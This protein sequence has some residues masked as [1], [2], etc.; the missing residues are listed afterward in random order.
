MEGLALETIHMVDIIPLLPIPYPP[1]G[2]SSYYIPCPN[3]DKRHKDKHLN[4]NLIKDVFRCPKCG[5]FGGVFDLYCRYTHY[6]REGV[7]YKLLRILSGYSAKPYVSR[8]PV[9]F[10][11]QG[12]G[13]THAAGLE[14]RHE[15]YSDLLS[16]LPLA[17]DH[18][19][20]L[21]Q[22][23]LS[24]QV[25][26]D[27]GYRTISVINEKSLARRLLANGH[28]LAGVP[29]FYRDID[30]Q[31]TFISNQRGVLIPVRDIKGRIQGMQVRRDNISKRKYRWISSNGMNGGQGAESWV[32][33]AGQPA[34][35]VILT[36]GPLKADVIHY[37]TG[38]TILAVPGVNSLKHLENTLA[39][40]IESGTKQVMTAFDMDF[41]QNSH[42]QTGYTEL[43]N[44]LGR[45]DL[46][47][48]TYLWDPAFNGLDDYIHKNS[49]SL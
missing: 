5:F 33:I 48:G 14:I 42:V 36:E 12:A 38:Q 22:R 47:F 32:H 7:R 28:N 4:I 2:R 34:E 11:T 21:L 40:L 49:I 19:R 17:A 13:D 18:M 6:P 3:C 24:E 20:N 44:L 30:G 31:W 45:M 25:I 46:R 39:G 37:L 41:I 9:L 1:H 8:G 10:Q 43:I 27:N 16:M 23:G 26:S 15:V 29:G 35:R